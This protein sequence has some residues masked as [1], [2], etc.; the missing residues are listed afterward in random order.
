VIVEM[1]IWGAELHFFPGP[2]DVA[3]Y[4]KLERAA[5]PLVLPLVW[6]TIKECCKTRPDLLNPDPLLLLG[7]I[8]PLIF[9]ISFYGV[10]ALG[11]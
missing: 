4:M 10:E 9:L 2:V 1:D 6:S 8:F 11:G 7:L 5:K 3:G